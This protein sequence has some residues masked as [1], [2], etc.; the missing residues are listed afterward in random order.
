[1]K[2]RIWFMLFGLASTVALLVNK[3][4]LWKLKFTYPT[5]YQSWQMSFAS[6]MFFS[7]HMFGKMPSKALNSGII[8]PWFPAILLFS[9]S[10]YSGSVSLSRL[11]IP[12]FLFLQQ[13]V[14]QSMIALMKCQQQNGPEKLVSLLMNSKKGLLMIVN[15]FCIVGIIFLM[16]TELVFNFKWMLI[17]CIA[18]CSYSVFAIRHQHLELQESDKLLV[19]SIF[20]IIVL[21]TVGMTTGETSVVFEFPFLYH[22]IFL[23]ACLCSGVFGALLMVSYSKLCSELKIEKVR[24]GNTIIMLWVS[25]ISFF[26]F[27]NELTAQ[28]TFLAFFGLCSTCYLCYL[29]QNELQQQSTPIPIKEIVI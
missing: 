25:G 16:K 29:I 3:Y 28:L 14:L 6:V 26:V 11:P 5:V 2:S 20:S 12:V 21:L 13:G 18:S 24:F 19:N 10:I 7:A 17:H 22:R 4:V 1:M 23:L 27:E 15:C 9:T 8:Y